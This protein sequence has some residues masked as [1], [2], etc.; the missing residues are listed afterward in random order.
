[1]YM[2]TILVASVAVAALMSAGPAMA[3]DPACTTNQTGSYHLSVTGNTFTTVCTHDTTK[4]DKSVVDGHGTRIGA[5]ETWKGAVDTKNGEQDGRLDAV[6]TKNG[7]QDGVIGQHTTDIAANKAAIID[8]GGKKA[9]KTYVDDQ[10][11]AQDETIK[12]HGKRITATEGRLDDNDKRLNT[13]TPSTEANLGTLENWGGHVDATLTNH[14][15]RITSAEN[16][17]DGHDQTL[18]LHSQQIAG[19]GRRVDKAFEGVAMAMSLQT[20]HVDIGKHIALT[21]GYANFEGYN[22]I[23]T[24]ATVRFD[25]TWQL[26]AGISYGTNTNQ[27][28]VKANVTAQW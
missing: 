10:N 25:Q 9:D 22:A 13:F 12:G 26:G 7:E 20:P 28:G 14:G 1:M 5:L 2:K 6:E 27:V 19:L 21:G 3:A 18:A 4:A 17:L 8:M 23:S 11:A 15:D 24:A 16:R